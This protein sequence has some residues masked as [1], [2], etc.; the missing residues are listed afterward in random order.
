MSDYLKKTVLG[1]CVSV[2]PGRL[3]AQ[4]YNLR[5]RYKTYDFV[6]PGYAPN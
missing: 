2:I 3:S 5:G 4:Y 6:Y 1:W